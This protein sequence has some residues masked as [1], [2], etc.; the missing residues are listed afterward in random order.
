M[1]KIKKIIIK[2]GLLKL[3]SLPFI[4]NAQ[5]PLSSI[6]VGVLYLLNGAVP[7]IIGIGVLVFLWGIYR[8]MFKTEE[9][10]KEAVSIIVMGVVILFVMVSVWGLVFVY[11]EIF[12]VSIQQGGLVLPP[13]PISIQGL[14]E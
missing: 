7:V 2:I 12:G 6:A 10:K 9:D 3:F 4:V 11:S 8:Y 1:N 13:K 14:K 5:S